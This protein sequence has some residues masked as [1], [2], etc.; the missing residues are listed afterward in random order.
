MLKVLMGHS[1]TTFP[2]FGSFKNNATTISTTTTAA[3]IAT[4]TTTTPFVSTSS[5]VEQQ[6]ESFD[7]TKLI[8]I[9]KLACLLCKRKFDT[10]DLLNKHTQLS[11]LHKVSYSLCLSVCLIKLKSNYYSFLIF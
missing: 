7:E 8:D 3:A 5:V 2:Y 11:N 6:E 1:R 10:V 9:N 4:T